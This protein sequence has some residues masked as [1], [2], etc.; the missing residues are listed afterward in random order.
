MPNNCVVRSQALGAGLVEVYD[1]W[2]LG[3]RGLGLRDNH[4][5]SGPACC[6]FRCKPR[7]CTCKSN[8]TRRGLNC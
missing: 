6:C 4:L 7:D 3:H 8:L 2:F 5:F 1:Y